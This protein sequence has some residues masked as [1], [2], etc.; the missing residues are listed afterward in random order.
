[1]LGTHFAGN[2]SGRVLATADGFR[3]VPYAAA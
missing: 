3:F 2:S 1:V